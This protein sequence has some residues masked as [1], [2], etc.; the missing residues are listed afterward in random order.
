MQGKVNLTYPKDI[1]SGGSWIAYSRGK[2]IACL[3]NGGFIKQTRKASYLKSRG[4]VLLESFDHDSISNFIE[5]VDLYG[6]EPF[7]ML[8][9]DFKNG[10]TFFSLVWDGNSK[11][12]SRVDPD[13]AHIWSSATLYKPEIAEQRK[14]WF[15]DWIIR[16]RDEDDVNI[17]RFHSGNHTSDS[18]NDIFM[19]RSE[20]LKTVSMTQIRIFEEGGSM[21][22]IDFLENKQIQIKLN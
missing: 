21:T 10:L 13:R 2:R 19:K 12:I 18:A 22:Y 9:L 20:L 4:L 17:T 5:N 6:I 1:E 11:H 14:K 3:L 7:T 8:L 16:Y 15:N